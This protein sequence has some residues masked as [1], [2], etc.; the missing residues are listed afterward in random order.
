MIEVKTFH[1]HDMELLSL[2]DEQKHLKPF[3]TKG[4]ATDLEGRESFT[5]WS[6]ERVLGCAGVIVL[7]P[8]RALCWTLLSS[9]LGILFVGVHRAVSRFLNL[10]KDLRLEA[11]AVA[12]FPEGQ[13]WLEMLGFVKE[14]YAKKFYADGR[15]AHLYVRLG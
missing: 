15:D 7:E 10:Q 3:L 11:Q 1:A 6:K 8:H 5:A 14:G 12:G 9:S 4:H 2:Q 13:R